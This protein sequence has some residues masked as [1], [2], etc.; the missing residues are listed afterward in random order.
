M[1]R[2]FPD[3]QFARYAGNTMLHCRSVSQSL[4]DLACRF[5]FSV[6]VGSINTAPIN[7]HR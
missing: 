4:D 3:Y 5:I 6:V 2:P 7:G 1:R